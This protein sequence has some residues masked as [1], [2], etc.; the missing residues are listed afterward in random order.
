MIPATNPT[1]R[2]NQLKNHVMMKVATSKS[3]NMTVIS[4]INVITNN[5]EIT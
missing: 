4:I 3:R 5:M 1:A 2:K